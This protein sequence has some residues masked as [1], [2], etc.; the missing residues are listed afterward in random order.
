[1]PW[2]GWLIAAGLVMICA[3]FVGSMLIAARTARRLNDKWNDEHDQ[4]RQD[5]GLGRRR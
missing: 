2:W 4:W 1:M 5:H 3:T